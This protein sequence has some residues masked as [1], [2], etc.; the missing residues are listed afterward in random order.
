M[1]KLVDFKTHP[2]W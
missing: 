1:E 2:A